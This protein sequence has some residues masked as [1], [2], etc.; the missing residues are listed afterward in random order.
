MFMPTYVI[1]AADW[2]VPERRPK[3]GGGIEMTP[4]TSFKIRLNQVVAA[5]LTLWDFEKD[6]WSTP[7]E[8][9]DGGPLTRALSGFKDED[10][11]MSA[12]FGGVWSPEQN[13][14]TAAPSGE[15]V[16]ALW[17]AWDDVKDTLKEDLAERLAP[18]RDAA[19][20]DLDAAVQF[21]RAFET[22]ANLVDTYQ[23]EARAFEDD[24]WFENIY[25]PNKSHWEENVRPFVAAAG[26]YL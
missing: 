10:G 25:L 26:A 8:E 9:K 21:D 12:L 2:S 24:P 7:W 1:S 17:S 14:F 13:S 23:G 20:G 19:S 3:P 15:A 16:N 4:D 22:Y 18:Q 5:L 6:V 11:Q